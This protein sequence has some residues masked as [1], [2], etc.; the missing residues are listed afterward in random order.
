MQRYAQ[1]KKFYAT[2]PHKL[3]AAEEEYLSVIEDS[4]M[5]EWEYW[6]ELDGETPLGGAM[7]VKSNLINNNTPEIDVH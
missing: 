1:S 7:G 3:D 4:L 6:E 5:A 2:L